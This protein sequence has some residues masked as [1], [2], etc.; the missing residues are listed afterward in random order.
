MLSFAFRRAELKMYSIAQSF[1]LPF[2]D[3]SAH[4]MGAPACAKKK[5]T[6]STMRNRGDIPEGSCNALAGGI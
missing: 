1:K 2:K 3:Q 5:E 6:G 4:Q